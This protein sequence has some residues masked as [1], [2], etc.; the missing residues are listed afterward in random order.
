MG[1]F[2]CNHPAAFISTKCDTHIFDCGWAHSWIC[3][4]LSV[5]IQDSAHENRK[6]GAAQD[7]TI[8]NFPLYFRSHFFLRAWLT[9]TS[10]AS[11]CAEVVD[12]FQFFPVHFQRM[13]PA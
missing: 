9:P 7:E 8:R 12:L 2:H 6:A 3:E 1:N 10:T 13:N 5:E 11:F 4:A